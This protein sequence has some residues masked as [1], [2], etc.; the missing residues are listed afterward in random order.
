[1]NAVG[2]KPK[3][4]FHDY[5]KNPDLFREEVRE[6]AETE[7][8]S[9]RDAKRVAAMIATLASRKLTNAEWC[10]IRD[11]GEE[12]V[13]QLLD[14]LRDPHLLLHPYSDNILDES[15]LKAVLELLEP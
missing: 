8:A 9:P 11:E 6:M 13:P 12:M 14:A 1:M 7:K 10:Q 4:D 15:P 3:H 5:V 2:K